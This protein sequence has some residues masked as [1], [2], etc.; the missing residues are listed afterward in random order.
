MLPFLFNKFEVLKKSGF[1]KYRL[2]KEGQLSYI[3]IIKI[4]K[5]GNLNIFNNSET[6]KVIY[7]QTNSKSKLSK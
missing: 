1:I 7:I 6:I 2:A 4:H 5:V 3:N